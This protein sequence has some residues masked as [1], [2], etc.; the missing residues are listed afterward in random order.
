MDGWMGIKDGYM[1]FPSH[2]CG[3]AVIV[4]LDLNQ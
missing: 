4:V 1:G 2:Q 3:C